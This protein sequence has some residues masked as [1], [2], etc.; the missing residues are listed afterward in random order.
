MKQLSNMKQQS[1]F[2]LI[3]LVMVIVILGIL[4]ATALPKFVDLSDD[5]LVAAKKGMSGGVK[6]AFAI[7]YAKQAAAGA[8]GA[9]ALP[10]VTELA[11]AMQPAG[12]AAATGVQVNI[13]G[14]NYT[15]PTYTDEACTT[16]TAA[17]GNTVQCVGD[18]P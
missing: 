2:T 7:E 1:G 4:A 5:A 15:V 16:A 14:T 6:S 13:N 11:A 9:A 18:I 12:T 17:V 8:V 10:T 3:E